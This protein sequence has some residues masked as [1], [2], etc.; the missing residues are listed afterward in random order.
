M[1]VHLFDASIIQDPLHPFL[2]LIVAPDTCPHTAHV[3]V[4]F[5]TFL[6]NLTS[7]GAFVK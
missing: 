2:S 5:L 6:S 4:S 1:F 3:K 7:F